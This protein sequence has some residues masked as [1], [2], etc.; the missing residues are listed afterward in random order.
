MLSQHSWL[1]L[2]ATSAAKRPRMQMTSRLRVGAPETLLSHLEA[3]SP[4]QK[5][6]TTSGLKAGTMGVVAG[7]LILTWCL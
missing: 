2:P 1:R 6:V 7:H 5:M 4:L 3:T